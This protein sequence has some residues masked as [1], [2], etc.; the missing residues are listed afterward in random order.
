MIKK[1]TPAPKPSRPNKSFNIALAGFLSLLLSVAFVY[2]RVGAK[3]AIN[4]RFQLENLT[5]APILGVVKDKAHVQQDGSIDFMIAN[6]L[7]I[8]KKKKGVK[9]A[10]SSSLTKEGKTFLANHT[11]KALAASGRKVLLIDVNVQN[12]EWQKLVEP[13]RQTSSH[14]EDFFM[15]NVALEKVI[16][17]AIENLDV[18]GFSTDCNVSQ[19][20]LSSTFD[21]RLNQLGENYDVVFF[22]CPAYSIASESPVF[23]RYSDYKVFIVR[24]D[25]TNVR[26]ISNIENLVKKYGAD[27]VG[28]VLNA[29]PAGMNYSGRFFGSRFQ[30]NPPKGFFATIVHYWKSYGKSWNI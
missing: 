24:Y 16:Y 25:F 7:P 11:A 20:Y 22:D 18:C 13:S 5:E 10:F 29:A 17:P 21:E 6:L 3:G 19:L 30:Y 23:M 14:L 4:S 9:I 28:V 12:S 2:I 27:Q 15:K 1:A 26:F 8:I